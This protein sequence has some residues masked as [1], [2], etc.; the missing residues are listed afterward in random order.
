VDPDWELPDSA[1]RV[2]FGNT[3]FELLPYRDDTI[4]LMVLKL[5]PML[6]ATS[7]TGR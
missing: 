6:G 2:I 3:T 1:D 5:W 4:A 7:N